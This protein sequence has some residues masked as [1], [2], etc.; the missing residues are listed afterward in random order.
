[1]AIVVAVVLSY[2]VY[3]IYLNQSVIIDSPNE[4]DIT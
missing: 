3:A 2:V 4:F 1:M